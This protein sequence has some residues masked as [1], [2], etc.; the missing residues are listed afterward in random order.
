MIQASTAA[1]ISSGM[2]LRITVELYAE[3]MG[4][5]QIDGDNR[6]VTFDPGPP[7][8]AACAASYF[9]SVEVFAGSDFESCLTEMSTP[10]YLTA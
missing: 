8:P 4:H 1:T 2:H 6:A 9:P 3:A 7:A 5:F 10:A